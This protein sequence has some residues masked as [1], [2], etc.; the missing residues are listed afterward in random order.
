MALTPEQIQEL[1]DRYANDFSD[2]PEDVM[3][4]LIQ[5]ESQGNPN[6]VSPKGAVGRTQV[7]PTTFPEINKD[8]GYNY[9]FDDFKRSPEMQDLYGKSY[10]SK[11]MKSLGGNV[12]A[13]LAAYNSGLGTVQSHLQKNPQFA[14]QF[15]TTGL[16]QETQD[17]VANIMSRVNGGQSPD[18][19]RSFIEGY[20]KKLAE[21]NAMRYLS[22]DQS[23]EYDPSFKLGAKPPAQSSG[24]AG[25]FNLMPPPESPE[26]D[27][28]QIQKQ[29]DS[30]NDA[31][32][33]KNYEGGSLHS[34]ILKKLGLPID[35]PKD[36]SQVQLKEGEYFSS[37]ELADANDPR[38]GGVIK[39]QDD[40]V[41][42]QK[43]KQ[44]EIPLQDNSLESLLAKV[45]GDP[46]KDKLLSLL[47]KLKMAQA[48]QS[49]NTG[50]IQLAKAGN[51]IADAFSAGRGANTT[52]LGTSA[53]DYAAENA[54]QGVKQLD[55]EIATKEADYKIKSMD[56]SLNPA[57][58]VSVAQ[59]G[60]LKKM[61]DNL[62]MDPSSIQA[63]GAKNA[64]E[65][66]QSMAYLSKIKADQDQRAAAKEEK[67]KLKMKISDKQAKDI[68]DYD[69]TLNNI[70]Q[71]LSVLGKNSNFTGSFDGRVPDMLASSDQVAW[72][73]MIG[74]LNDQYRRLITGAA[75][76]DKELKMLQ[77]RLPQATDTYKN[78]IAKANAF[79]KTTAN[80]KTAYLAG[81]TRQG[82][83][84][85]EFANP[86]D[87][88]KTFDSK[89]NSNVPVQSPE[90]AG[91][92]RQQQ[93]NGKVALF[94][95][96]TRKF[97]GW[98]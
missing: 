76:G 82:K 72:R 62:G 43:A 40:L 23:P 56:E 78:F 45:G 46:E 65:L 38:S 39:N 37:P 54:D 97:V 92:V 80:S 4:A 79:A 70:D 24:V 22:K 14:Q 34:D 16:P 91:L 74:L 50:M 33:Q 83:D 86:V 19:F 3:Q 59:T 20:K 47:E 2:V 51:D 17:Y 53:L 41:A 5:R 94:E 44:P 26:S 27:Y 63:M 31:R 15:Q 77:S 48:N 87:F 67:L 10:L 52:K 85:G 96:N 55:K 7:M 68:T 69:N 8:L 98:E 42:E 89:A 71:I 88:D 21:S 18:Q 1:K 61:A 84:I 75:A 95:P 9:S 36:P 81:L 30:Q 28:T 57:S 66:M 11:Q 60:L 64:T 32:T 93:D 25:G 35:M 6:A 12:P 73:S 29:L 90:T 58:A 49:Q 13:S